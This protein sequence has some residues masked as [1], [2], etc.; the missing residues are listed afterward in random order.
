MRQLKILVVDDSKVDRMCL[1]RAFRKFDSYTVLA[2]EAVDA[3]SA[4]RVL[5]KESFDAMF[6]DINMPGENGF[7]VLRTLRGKGQGTWPLV[8]MYSSSNHPDDVATAYQESANAYL[9]KPMS[10]AEV[11]ALAGHC[12]AII[13]GV[14]PR[15][16]PI[17]P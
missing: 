5:E 16:G 11:Q 17:A 13:D 14:S 4:V 6:L 15:V 1:Q 9:C 12:L 3:T 2:E 7:H 8:F 10:F